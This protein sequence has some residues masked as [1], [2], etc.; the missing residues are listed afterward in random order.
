MPYTSAQLQ[1]IY[2]KVH[3]GLT[4]SAATITTLDTLAAQNLAASRTD[5]QTYQS[6]LDTADGDTSVAIGAYQYFTG[7]TPTQA[8]LTFL[9]NSATNPT[10]LNDPYY[11]QFDQ[12]NRYINF[13]QN[14]GLV[15]EGKA[16]FTAAY[17]GFTFAA[18]VAKA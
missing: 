14:L 11:V 4:P 18:A 10:D 6:V 9:V 15:G 13:A 2:T 3:A 17:G 1:A 12:T 8:G 7:L 16:F 5:A